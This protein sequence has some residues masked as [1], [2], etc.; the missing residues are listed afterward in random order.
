MTRLR[1]SRRE[2]PGIRRVRRGKGWAYKFPDNAAVT[3]PQ[4]RHRIDSLVIPPAWTDVWISPHSNGHIQAIGTDQ[5]G[6]RQYLY[7]ADWQARRHQQKFV[8]MVQFA[9]VL[10]QS[11]EVVAEQL[12][13]GGL[14]RDRV[15]AAAFRMLDLGHFRIGG[16]SYATQNKS[17]GL[18]TLLREHVRRHG[19]LLVF[20]YTA[21]GGIAHEERIADPDLLDVLAA[22]R[23]RRGDTDSLLGYRDATG[24]HR[25]KG[26]DINGFI[27]EVTGLKVSAKD[28]RTWHGTDIA[29]VA[30]AE[31]YALHQDKPWT[32]RSRKKAVAR[33]VKATSA[34]L[35]N[36][37]TVARSAYI[38]P[39][40]VDLFAREITVAPDVQRAR[41]LIAADVADQIAALAAT[42]DVEK[43]VVTL[44]Q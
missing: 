42:P 28:F 33:A 23:R 2:L 5:A 27:K 30:L 10:P 26:S 36:T 12:A 19:D 1:R 43:A 21:K 40:V 14:G 6:R 11:R 13:A 22:L 8:R 17:Y 18:S 3:D 20:S 16:E 37:P 39:R 38:D 41:E 24:W 31:E 35:G 29:A 15:L 25:L 9:G 32:E 4:V 44:L 7:H 34:R